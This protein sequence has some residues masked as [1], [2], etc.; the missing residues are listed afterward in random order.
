MDGN[1][2]PVK[3]AVMLE[4]KPFHVKWF[5]VVVMV[6]LSFSATNLTRLSKDSSFSD[7]FPQL[8]SCFYFSRATFMHSAFVFQRLLAPSGVIPSALV[9]QAIMFPVVIII[10]LNICFSAFLALIRQAARVPFVP[11]K[12]FRR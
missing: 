10:R 5:R 4:A 8:S 11:V 9:V 2:L 3:L 1:G 12:L 7:S 6:G